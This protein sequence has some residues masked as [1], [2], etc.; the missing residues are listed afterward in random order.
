MHLKLQNSSIVISHCMNSDAYNYYCSEEMI[1]ITFVISQQ[2]SCDRTVFPVMMKYIV[3]FNA[4]LW[5][6]SVCVCVH[7][8]VCPCVCVSV[9]CM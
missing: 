1:K 3:S 2:Y 5:C 7:L 8:S 9:C 6:A 4:C